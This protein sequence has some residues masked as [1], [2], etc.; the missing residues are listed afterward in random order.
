MMLTHGLPKLGRLL[1]GNMKFA[2]PLG[3]GS[4]TSLVF[5]VL[6]EAG[7]SILLIIGLASRF[8]AAT[9]AFTMGVAAFIQHADDDFGRKEKA[10]L[11]LVIYVILTIT[12]PGKYSLDDRLK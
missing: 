11:Y 1:D 10:F 6:T 2:D 3:I 12:G 8:S 7:A 4:G 5:A 9:L